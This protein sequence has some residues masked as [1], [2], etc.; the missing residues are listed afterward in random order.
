MNNKPE[1]V[2]WV[3]ESPSQRLAPRRL[4]RASFALALVAAAVAAG[5]CKKAAPA[6]PP[7]PAVQVMDVTATNVPLEAE[8][9]G[10]LDSPQN[11][12]IRARVEAFVQEMP[13]TEGTNVVAGQLLFKLDDAPYKEKLAA[14][15]GSLAEAEA[16]LA[17]YQADVDR[18]RPLAEKHAVPKQDL[19]N[20]VASVDVGKASVFSAKAR[21]EA[22]LLELSYC[23][24]CAPTSGLIGAK[25]V[26]IGELVGKGTPTLMAT[27]ST[28]DPIWAYCSVS[29]VGLLN[30]DDYARRTGKRIVDAPVT[31]ILANGTV[32]PEKGKIVFIDRA[33]DLKTGTMR[34]RAEFRNPPIPP[35]PDPLLRPGMFGRLKL[36]LGTRTNSIL[37]PERAVT[38]LQ[39]RSFVW[40]IG[41]DNKATQRPVKVGQQIGESLLIL[42]NLEAGERIVVEGVQKVRDGTEVKPMTAAQVAEAVK[43]AEGTPKPAKEG[44]T[45]RG[46]E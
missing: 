29:E 10:Q 23:T 38:E 35:N 11:V 40:V 21:V 27:I 37:V 32:H 41:S 24:N 6:P 8:I 31:L 46:K 33:V 7:P 1:H 3:H 44:E 15:R 43:Q 4:D 30:A 2:P 16:A 12:E 9:I 45:K 42:E 18:L 13:F 25:Q 28:L 26:S 19:D 17:K 22:A 34:V 36:D 20:A 14:A 39:G 5:G